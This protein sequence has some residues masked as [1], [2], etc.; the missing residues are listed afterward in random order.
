MWLRLLGRLSLKKKIKVRMFALDLG[1]VYC[2]WNQ[3]SHLESNRTA[4]YENKPKHLVWQSR[5]MAITWVF[6]TLVSWWIN[7]PWSYLSG[8]LMWD[9]KLINWWN[10]DELVFLLV[11]AKCFLIDSADTV[12]GA[13]PRRT[14]NS[15]TNSHDPR[16]SGSV[17]FLGRFLAYIPY[18]EL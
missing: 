16:F 11:S 7:Q 2:S 4:V 3:S 10:H 17:G 6:E 12:L 18:S 14:Q 13:L 9:N 5:N 15:V 8:L 1:S